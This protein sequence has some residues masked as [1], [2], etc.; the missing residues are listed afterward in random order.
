MKYALFIKYIHVKQS[1]FQLNL[2]V[3]LFTYSILTTNVDSQHSK[4][5]KN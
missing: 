4:N 1:C 3:A 5:I 2:R